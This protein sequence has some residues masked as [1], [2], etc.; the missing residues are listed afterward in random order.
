MSSDSPSNLLSAAALSK[1]M[2]ANL[3]PNTSINNSYDAVALAAH[4]SMQAIGFRLVGLGEDHKIEAHS[5]PSEPSPLPA[6]WNATK[7]SYAFRYAH[8]QSSMEYLLKINR[9]GN[10]AVVMGMGMGDDRTHSFD[11]KVQEYISEGNLPLTPVKEGANK[12]EAARKLVDVFISIGRLSDLGNL[13]RLKVIQKLAPSLHKEGYEETREAQSSSSR[14]QRE[15]APGREADRP[16][17]DPLRADRD[18]PARPYPLHD[19]LAHPRRPMPDPMPGF[20]D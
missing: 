15:P 20:E 11:L 16:M 14:Q 17:R 8:S 3:A 7:G 9:M 6:E 4:A 1:R 5:D 18:P 12:D 10:K 13:M 2:I 19:P